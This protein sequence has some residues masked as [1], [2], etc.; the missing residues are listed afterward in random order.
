MLFISIVDSE[1]IPLGEKLRNFIIS[2]Y[3]SLL[4][5]TFANRKSCNEVGSLSPDVPPVGLN[6]QSSNSHVKWTI[7]PKYTLSLSLYNSLFVT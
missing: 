3:L 7:V 2:H 1:E 6:R 4:P 5:F